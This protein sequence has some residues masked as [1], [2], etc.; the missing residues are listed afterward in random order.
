VPIMFSYRVDVV[1]WAARLKQTA[2]HL[3]IILEVGN[4]ED[5][6]RALN[7]DGYPGSTGSIPNQ[8][9]LSCLWLACLLGRSLVRLVK[10]YFSFY[11]F[12]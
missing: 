9:T 7:R 5:F 2:Q 6:V 1:S 10:R 8:E 11:C 3:A 4:R 12:F